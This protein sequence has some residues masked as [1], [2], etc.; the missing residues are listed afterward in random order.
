MRAAGLR[1]SRVSSP[2]LKASLSAGDIKG[3]QG[4]R[5][6]EGGMSRS[7]NNS[8]FLSKKMKCSKEEHDRM[9]EIME[10]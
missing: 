4:Q 2:A 5:P 7:S 10:Q 1:Y 3:Q 8:T 6:T 9:Y